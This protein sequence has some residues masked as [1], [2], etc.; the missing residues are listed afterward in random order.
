M[1]TVR[2]RFTLSIVLLAVMLPLV[3]AIA[4][5][6]IWQSYRKSVEVAISAGR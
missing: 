6:V 3:A 4:G 5:L 2:R 1:T